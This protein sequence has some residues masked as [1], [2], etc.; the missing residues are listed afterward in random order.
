[1]VGWAALGL[2]GSGRGPPGEA[3]GDLIGFRKGEA[4]WLLRGLAELIVKGRSR[5]HG[6]HWRCRG[7]LE[8]SN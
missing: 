8:H 1:M 5:S 7:H 4:G 3:N 6:E 2:V